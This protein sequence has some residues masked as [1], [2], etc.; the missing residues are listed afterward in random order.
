MSLRIPILALL[1]SLGACHS[2]TGTSERAADSGA[3]AL[4][5]NA[6][7]NAAPVT[8]PAE[9]IAMGSSYQWVAVDAPARQEIQ[10]GPFLLTISKQSQTEFEVEPVFEVRRAGQ[11]VRI[12][13]MAAQPHHAYHFAPIT[14]GPGEPALMVQS[15]TGGAHCCADVRLVA[16]AG[17]KLGVIPLGW[18]DGDPVEPP[19]DISGDGRADFVFVDNAFLYA[20][21]SYAASY[22]P[23]KV[24]NVVD[25]EVVDVSGRPAFRTLFRKEA[26]TAGAVCRKAES[27]Y[28]RN[29]ACPS[30]VA[31]AARIGKLD[32]AWRDMIASYDPAV[33]WDLPKGCRAPAA[34]GSCPEGERVD[35]RYPEALLRFLKE[36]GYVDQDWQPPAGS[37]K[38]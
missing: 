36:H 29:G 19:R 15:W 34:D 1:A 31:A 7:E 10:A 35:A 18:W 37:L 22:A 23:P 38:T 20:F 33:D 3:A 12:D 9:S 13:G 26:E 28:A 17:G 16:G 32:A 21:A 30:Y 8:V 11:S 2:S 25:G 5:A 24:L 4:A 6:Q 14:L 27:G